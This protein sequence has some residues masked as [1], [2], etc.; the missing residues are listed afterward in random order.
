MTLRWLIA[1]TFGSAEWDASQ[2][3]LQRGVETFLPQII[4]G[5]RRNRFREPILK[6]L[7]PGYLFVGLEID[8]SVD[9]VRAGIGIRGLIRDGVNYV[10]VPPEG[11]KALRTQAAEAYET[12]TPHKAVRKEWYIGQWVQVPCGILAGTPVQI[13]RVDRHEI[14]AYVGQLKVTW[15][16]ELTLLQSVG[17]G[18]AQ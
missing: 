10:T 16:P 14:E 5:V 15:A 13:T 11:M 18:A 4:V 8:Q 2:G 9:M 6:P 17:S 12:S 1:M 7:F 3:L